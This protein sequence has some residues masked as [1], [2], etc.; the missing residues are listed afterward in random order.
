MQRKKKSAYLE[1]VED[2]ISMVANDTS[3]AKPFALE[4]VQT[5][6]QSVGVT[7]HL[8]PGGF[9]SKVE[10]FVLDE[11]FGKLIPIPFAPTF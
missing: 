6:E 4:T 10:C 7:T 3:A 11:L 5:S 2:I 9:G 8:T 1:P